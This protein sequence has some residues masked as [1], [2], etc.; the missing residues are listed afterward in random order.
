MASPA[1]VDARNL[2]DRS[3]LPPPGIRLPRRRAELSGDGPRRRHRRG[4][5]PRFAPLR[6][7]PRPRATRSSPS[8]TCSPARWT[9]SS[10]CSAARVHVRR[11]R[12]LA[13]RVGA[14]ARST[15]SCTSPARRRPTDFARI[16]I[17]I[18]KVGSLGTHNCLGLAKAKGARFFLAST[19]EVY[20]DPQVHPQPEEYWGHVNPIGPRGVY[21]EAKRFAEAMTMAYHRYPRRR[22]PHR[23]HLQHLR[24][25]DAPRR[26]P[27]RSRTS[28]C[29]RCAGEPITIYGDGSQTRSFCYVDDE[30]A[31]VPRPA[32]RRPAPVRSTSATPPSSPSASSPS[33]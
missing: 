13:V 3:A 30:V 24:A 28:S 19:S 33:W 16:P 25:A 9:T 21:D 31:R 18:L 27:G 23:A 20:G 15:R 22:R 10:T 32:R 11:T 29:R 17:Q 6:A 8:T 14:R 12:R 26:R 5:V 2:L 1:V 4:R 7:V